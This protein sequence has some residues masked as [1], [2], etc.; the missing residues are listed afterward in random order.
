MRSLS[1]CFLT[2]VAALLSPALALGT[3]GKFSIV[4][5]GKGFDRFITI[6]LENQDFAKAVKDAHFADL[7][8][9]GILL[10]KYYAQTHPSQP[11]YIASISGD[12]FGL[13]HDDPVHIPS[14][15]STVVD[16]LDTK[17]ISFGGYFEDLPGP[18]YMGIAS[19]RPSSDKWDYVRKH[20]PY[21]SFDSIT[22][23]GTRLW[24]VGSFDDFQRDLAA[25]EIPQFVFMSPNMNHDG[26]NTTLE[27]ATS[28]VHDFLTPLLADTNNK[29][30]AAL[31]STLIL[32]TFDESE[33]YSQ[34]NKIASLLLGSAVP[35]SLR[36]TEDNTFYTHYS[37]LASVENNWGLPNLGRYDVGANVWQF[38]ADATGYKNPGDP[39]TLSGINS[40][41][42]Y[43]GFLHSDPASRVPIPPPNL[44]LVGA[45][46]Q[47]VVDKVKHA[48]RKAAEELSPYDGIGEPFDGGQ[49][50]P[51]YVPQVSNV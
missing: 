39:D 44:K 15:V 2:S 48:W 38:V 24:S 34:P 46:G 35:T 11:N 26:H 14:N 28:W 12:Y 50:L 20:N 4:P 31:A 8:R 42:S 27:Q 16:L 25:A 13:D 5:G 21:V 19:S 9:E 43:P 51:E 29:N 37:I 49:W 41:V 36:G 23:N 47:G 32:L 6:W 17:G 18:G 40:S 45:G 22:N 1:C 3:G 30:K 10:T 33:D 7:K